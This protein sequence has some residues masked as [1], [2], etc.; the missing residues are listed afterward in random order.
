MCPSSVVLADN[1]CYERWKEPETADNAD[2]LQTK[3]SDQGADNT[4]SFAL[5]DS[6]TVSTATGT[7]SRACL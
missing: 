1:S 5:W 7:P 3:R 6:P 2:K 4:K